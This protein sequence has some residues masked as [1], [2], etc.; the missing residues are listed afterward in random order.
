LF[1]LHNNAGAFYQNLVTV[2]VPNLQPDSSRFQN[3]GISVAQTSLELVKNAGRLP[4]QGLSLCG[5][6]QGIYI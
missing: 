6:A 5:D 4:N 2:L 3:L 1:E